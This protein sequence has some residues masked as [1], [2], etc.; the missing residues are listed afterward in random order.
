MSTGDV[1]TKFK[2]KGGINLPALKKAYHA[3]L[4]L[5]EDGF[6]NLND[7][8]RFTSKMNEICFRPNHA[9]SKKQ[10]NLYARKIPELINEA[11]PLKLPNAVKRILK[12]RRVKKEAV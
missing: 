12:K 2:L 1:I 11:C 9:Y 6:G 4:S 3:L 7:Y 5:G 8:N 10:V